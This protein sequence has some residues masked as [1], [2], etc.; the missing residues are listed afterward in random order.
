MAE[1]TKTLKD[2]AYVVIGLGVIATQKV[3]VRRQ[4]LRKQLETQRKQLETQASTAREQLEA[5]ASGAREL[6]ETQTAEART[7]LLKLAEDLESRIEPL[8][9]QVEERLPAQAARLFKEARGQAKE[10]RETVKTRLA[11]AP[12]K[13]A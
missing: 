7:R 12:T 5:A 13:A 11:P 9:D 3:N 1:P 2:A 10:A 8:V 4:E 6:V